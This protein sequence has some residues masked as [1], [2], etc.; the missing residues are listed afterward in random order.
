ML[1]LRRCGIAAPMHK[2]LEPVV[3][4]AL[5][6]DYGGAISNA[7]FRFCRFI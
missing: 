7:E 4:V 6:V 2:L 5:S 1:C 3:L